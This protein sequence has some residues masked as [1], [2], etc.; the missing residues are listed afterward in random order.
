MGRDKGQYNLVQTRARRGRIVL[1]T[2]LHDSIPVYSAVV[3]QG[4]QGF[5][6]YASAHFFLDDRQRFK[7]A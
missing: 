4:R 7:A 3:N 6:M 1:R 5:L 2:E